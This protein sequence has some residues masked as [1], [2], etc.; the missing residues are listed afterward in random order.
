[1]ET[2]DYYC[3]ELLAMDAVFENISQITNKN[4]EIMTLI[5]GDNSSVIE[6]YTENT[7]LLFSMETSETM[8]YINGK[9]SIFVCYWMLVCIG[10]TNN[11]NGIFGLADSPFLTNYNFHHDYFFIHPKKIIETTE[12][13]SNCTLNEKF[14]LEKKLKKNEKVPWCVKCF[15][16]YQSVTS[17]TK[18]MNN[19]IKFSKIPKS[20]VLIVVK[21]IQ[22]ATQTYDSL[23]K[24]QV[25]L[26]KDKIKI[27]LVK[28]KIKET[29][30]KLEKIIEK[31]NLEKSFDIA[32]LNKLLNDRGG[33]FENYIQ[34]INETDNLVKSF[35]I[36]EE[37]TFS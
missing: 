6:L 29:E 13:N 23:L 37:S 10:S 25:F 4:T 24:M 33:T 3:N 8:E 11:C 5:F 31:L 12:C 17:L 18:I 21:K 9:P 27:D 32:K 7:S 14:I 28:A 26:T 15:G 35:Q 2:Y 20:S 34:T 16:S 1:M 22:K 19:K 36:A 30:I